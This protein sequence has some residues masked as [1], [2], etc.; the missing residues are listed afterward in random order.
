MVSGVGRFPGSGMSDLQDIYASWRSRSFPRGSVVAALD[1][2]HADLA[3][4]D[5][6]VAEYV[7]PFVEQGQF[8]RPEDG[9]VATL[10]NIRDRAIELEKTGGAEDKALAAE[11]VQYVDLL[12]RVYKA[13]L[14]Q[15]R[16]GSAA[17]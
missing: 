2:L 9:V 1:G 14:S 15:A 10:Q 8:S 16:P 6:W 7:V 3:L 5:G 13:F 12:E 11:Y 4:A 17:S